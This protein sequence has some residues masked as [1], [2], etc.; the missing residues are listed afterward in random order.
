MG[1]IR[2]LEPFD[3]PRTMKFVAAYL[4]ANLAGHEQPSKADITKILE[5]VGAST[6]G[7]DTFLKAVEG[8]NP[9][10]LIAEGQK[11][12]AAV[13]AGGAAPAAAAPAAKGAAAAA[14]PAAKP[15]EEEPEPE[16]EQVS[17]DLFD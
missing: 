2:R 5:S 12:L 13:P 10:D 1:E 8:K 14:A 16:E 4:L 9:R 6:E 7:L 11:K 3:D 15:K 17:F